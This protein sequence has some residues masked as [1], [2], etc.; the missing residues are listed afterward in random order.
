M[1]EV[2][3]GYG[4]F[5]TKIGEREVVCEEFDTIEEAKERIKVYYKAYKGK[6]GKPDGHSKIYPV[7]VLRGDKEIK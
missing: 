2:F 7:V 4:I 6:N 3:N 5:R 1:K